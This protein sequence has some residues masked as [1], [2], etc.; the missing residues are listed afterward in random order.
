MFF[1]LKLKINSYFIQYILSTVFSPNVHPSSPR[2]TPLSSPSEKKHNQIPQN[3]TKSLISRQ[4]KGGRESQEQTR[5]TATPIAA[6][7]LS[8]FIL[9]QPLRHLCKDLVQKPAGPVLV[10]IVSVN[11]LKSRSFNSGLSAPGVLQ[12]WLFK[13]KSFHRM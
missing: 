6:V 2:Y 5:V 3:K 10:A 11:P 9:N 13:I 4:P 12:M 7:R 1:L 8:K